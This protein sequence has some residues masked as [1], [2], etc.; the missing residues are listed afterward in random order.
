MHE[1]DFT[2]K[3]IR[4]YLEK[5]F[6]ARV[7][8]IHGGP[9]SE[10]GTPDLLCCLTIGEKQGAFAGFE[11]KKRTNKPSEI[12]LSVIRSIQKAGGVGGIVFTD[13]WKEDIDRILSEKI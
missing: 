13:T 7:F 3:F 5:K 10:I 12:Q 11:I 9:F 6:K 2:R 8:K 4:P 1:T